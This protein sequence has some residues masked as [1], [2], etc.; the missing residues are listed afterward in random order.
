MDM[1]GASVAIIVVSGMDM[2]ASVVVAGGASVVPGGASVVTGGASVVSLGTGVVSVGGASVVSG[3]ASASVV[4]GNDGVL[5]SVGSGVGEGVSGLGGQQSDS[6]SLTVA[7]KSLSAAMVAAKSLAVPHVAP[8]SVG[9]RR[10]GSSRPLGQNSHISTGA[11]VGDAVPTMSD[12][13]VVG[14]FG[15][16][17]SVSASLVNWHMSSSDARVSAKALATPQVAPSSV[18][19]K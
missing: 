13:E 15:G 5:S 6:A 19:S 12:G 10:S 16:Q 2:G 11:G 7:Q 9:R 14:C 4:G 8:S 18:G 1:G 17:Q 3:G